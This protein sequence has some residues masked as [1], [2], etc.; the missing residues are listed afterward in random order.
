VAATAAVLYAQFCDVYSCSTGIL[1]VFTR[2]SKIPFAPHMA[3]NM[4]TT[5]LVGA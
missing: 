4:I 1:V 2:L 3:H 5:L